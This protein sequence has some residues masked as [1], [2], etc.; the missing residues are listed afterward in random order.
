MKNFIFISPEF[1]KFH[2]KFCDKLKKNGIT[3][4]GVSSTPKDELKEELLT[5]LSDYY[6]VS[7]LDNYDEVMRAVAFFTYKYGKIDWIESNSSNY[8]ELDSKLRKDFNITTGVDSDTVGK[9][10]SRDDMKQCYRKAHIST[11]RYAPV[12]TINKAKLFIERVGYPIVI[13]P[14]LMKKSYKHYEINNEK[15]LYNFFENIDSKEKYIMEELIEG[16]II[17]YDGICNSKGEVL[18]EACHIAPSIMN[19]INNED[20]SYYTNIKVSNRLSA[21]GK[22]VIKGFDI[23]SRFFHLEFIKLNQTKRGL[24]KAGRYV[25]LEADVRPAGGYTADMINYANGVDIY[26]LWADMIAFDEIRHSYEENKNYC[27][28]ASRRDNKNYLHTKDEIITEYG[29]YIV[30]NERLPEPFSN[31]MGNEIYAARLQTMKQLEHFID[32]VLQKQ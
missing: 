29:N 31:S 8:L 21:A 27:V 32:F 16:N 15:E 17:T 11:L 10:I 18:M 26:Q 13:K 5:C 7:S 22:K 1:P 14:D 30:M 19:E 20:M 2:Y 12:T 9:Y 28:C 25:A 6:Q 4:L 23:K 3:V 24:G